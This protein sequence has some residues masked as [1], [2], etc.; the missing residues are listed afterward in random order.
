MLDSWL[1]MS[2]ISNPDYE[3][4]GKLFTDV[5]EKDVQIQLIL[6]VSVSFYSDNFKLTNCKNSIRNFN[7][8]SPKFTSYLYY[9]STHIHT[10][11]RSMHEMTF[12]FFFVCLFIE[13]WITLAHWQIDTRSQLEFEICDWPFGE[14][15][16]MDIMV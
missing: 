10:H 15:L 8:T 6:F 5:W 13:S 11:I 4:C 12:A 7:I 14:N 16:G 1:I 2:I 3:K 9:T